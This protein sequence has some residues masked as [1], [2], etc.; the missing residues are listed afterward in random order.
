[1]FVKKKIEHKFLCSIDLDLKIERMFVI[2]RYQHLL[3]L[4]DNRQRYWYLYQFECVNGFL[5]GLILCHK[6][7]Y[8]DSDI[9]AIRRNTSVLQIR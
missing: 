4:S 8:T 6:Q 7:R 2:I 9:T 5:K 1:M 3:L